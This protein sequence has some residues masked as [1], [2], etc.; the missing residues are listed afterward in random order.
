M[1][2]DRR[3]AVEIEIRVLAQI[4]RRLGVGRRRQLDP[5]RQAEEPIEAGRREVAGI[6]LVAVGGHERQGGGGVVQCGELPGLVTEAARAAVQA[7]VPVVDRQ[8]VHAVAEPEAPLA[9]AI[10]IAARDGAEIGRVPD[11]V[12]DAVQ[13]ED[14]PLEPPLP[15]RHDEVAQHRPP[16]DDLGLGAGFRAERHLVNG[17]AVDLAEDAHGHGYMSSKN[18]ILLARPRR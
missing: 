4:D 7:V 1:V 14:H 13:P 10:A 9:D 11:V 16:A 18:G 6:A 15:G 2:Q 5:Q 3:R 12:L 8:L 17:A